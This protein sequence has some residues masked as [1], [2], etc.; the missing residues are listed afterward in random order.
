MH[1]LYLPAIRQ[2][3]DD[4]TRSYRQQLAI[5]LS[6]L[7]WHARYLPCMEEKPAS[8]LYLLLL[9]WYSM[10]RSDTVRPSETAVSGGFKRAGLDLTE[11]DPEQAQ[12]WSAVEKGADVDDVSGERQPL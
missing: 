9:I 12:P 2:T 1:L 7:W 4:V 10:P 6:M 3:I 11:G 8:R 5:L